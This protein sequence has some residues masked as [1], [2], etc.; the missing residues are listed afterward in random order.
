MHDKELAEREAREL[1]RL[2]NRHW[3]GPRFALDEAAAVDRSGAM[4]SAAPVQA[5]LS[6]HDRAIGYLVGGRDYHD[7]MRTETFAREVMERSEE[8][9]RDWNSQVER[10]SEEGVHVIYTDG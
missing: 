10:A 4:S 9:T 8:L 3:V 7:R 5:A 2:R 6:R 1:R